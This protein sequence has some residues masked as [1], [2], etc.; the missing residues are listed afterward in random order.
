[1]TAELT[2][3]DVVA[4][5]PMW[6]WSRGGYDQTAATDDATSGRMHC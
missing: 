6:Q 2:D 1:M 3:S 5:G 4:Y